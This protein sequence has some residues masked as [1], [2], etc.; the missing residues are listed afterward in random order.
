M[1]RW[2]TMLDIMQPCRTRTWCLLGMRTLG[3]HVGFLPNGFMPAESDE[4]AE[5]TVYSVGATD[6][7]V[8]G[9]GL[10]RAQPWLDRVLVRLDPEQGACACDRSLAVSVR[11]VQHW[12]SDELV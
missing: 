5:D 6:D 2:S 10:D 4:T 9:L 8:T 12:T 3:V 1:E 11:F 7:L